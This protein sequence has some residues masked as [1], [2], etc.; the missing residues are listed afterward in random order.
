MSLGYAFL[1][2]GIG[3]FEKAVATLAKEVTVNLVVFSRSILCRMKHGKVEL[4]YFTND[5]VRNL[6]MH[7]G[8]GHVYAFISRGIRLTFGIFENHR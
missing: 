1:T 8:I 4:R 3:D 5:V 2:V 7:L 6:M